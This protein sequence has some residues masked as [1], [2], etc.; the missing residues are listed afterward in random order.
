MPGSIIGRPAW[1]SLWILWI[2]KGDCD[3]SRLRTS[4][5]CGE[6]KVIMSELLRTF[7]NSLGCHQI[8]DR[9]F[10][11]HDKPMPFC[12]RCLGAAIGQVITIILWIIIGLPS[13]M[14]CILLCLP[15]LIDWSLQEFCQISS[16]NIRRLITGIVGG[17]G[18]SSL[19]F[20]IVVYIISYV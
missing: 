10:R 17:I 5:V 8:P 14:I 20:G 1:S 15:M 12:A 18:F 4:M 13:L 9:C 16:T 3:L 11:V 7:A 19:M 2:R 6:N